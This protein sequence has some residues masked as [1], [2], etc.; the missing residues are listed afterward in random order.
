MLE[1]GADAQRRDITRLDFTAIESL[2]SRQSVGALQE[3]APNDADLALILD[4]GLR[5]PDHGRL[6]P[7][8]FVLIRGAARAAFAGVLIEALGRREEDP[9]AE[10]VQRLW[11][12][13]AAVPL[14]IGI[15]AKIDP[16]ASIPEIEQLLSAGAA[17][18]NLLN[19]IHMLG[20]GGMWM[21]GAHVYDR[22]VNEALGFSS[23]DRLVGLLFVGT[24]QT[25]RRQ[26]VPLARGDHVREWSGPNTGLWS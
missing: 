14:V 1:P 5:A 3:P 2:L 23:P 10:K 17:A 12:R 20:Y 22:G 24:A 19:A 15:G 6:R 16:D 18:M 9:P 4:A 21:T 13:I 11:N 25:P 8:R 26:T 7:W